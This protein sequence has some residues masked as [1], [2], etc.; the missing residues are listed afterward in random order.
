MTKQ[1]PL[2]FDIENLETRRLLAGNL[3]TTLAG[4]SLTISGD[5]QDNIVAVVELNSGHAVIGFDTAI[6][7]A[8]YSTNVLGVD[9]DVKLIEGITKD[10]TAILRGGD[11]S[12]LVGGGADGIDLEDV[13]GSE[14]PD[15]GPGSIPRDLKIFTNGGRDT[16]VVTVPRSDA[17]SELIQAL[18]VKMW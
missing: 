16:V 5:S 12:I 1:L 2:E 3:T 9:I 7:D 15:F 17:T 14:D 11:D 8:D 6:A 18:E 13:F 4:G 10:V